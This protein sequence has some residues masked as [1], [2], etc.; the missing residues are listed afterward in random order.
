[1]IGPGHR[2]TGDGGLVAGRLNTI[3]GEGATVTGGSGNVASGLG[4]SVSGGAGNTGG[5]RDMVII[6]G[7]NVNDFIDFTIQP[8]AP[9]P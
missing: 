9:F 5:G 3:S 7:Q 4:A 8:K 1:V 2:Y 6:G